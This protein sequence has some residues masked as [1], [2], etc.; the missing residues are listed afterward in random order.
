[1]KLKL[2]TLTLIPFLAFP[3]MAQ[4]SKGTL[5]ETLQSMCTE[6]QSAK[7]YTGDK[8]QVI[9]QSIYNEVAED[10]GIDS[11]AMVNYDCKNQKFET[12]LE[13]VSRENYDYNGRIETRHTS[14]NYNLEFN[15]RSKLMKI[16]FGKK[17]F[18]VNY[19]GKM[20]QFVLSLEIQGKLSVEKNGLISSKE[21]NRDI[22]SIVYSIVLNG[23]NDDKVKLSMKA[24]NGLL[25]ENEGLV[26]SGEADQSMIQTDSFVKATNYNESELLIEK[27][28]A[29]T[30]S[31]IV[32]D[33]QRA[34][35]DALVNQSNEVLLAGRLNLKEV[36]LAASAQKDTEAPAIQEVVKCDDAGCTPIEVQ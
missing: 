26:F 29:L 25:A 18:Y 23:S 1:M 12:L 9:S 34:Q 35:H 10:L 7:S 36:I 11:Y 20:H 21:M 15:E 16:N 6:S 13:V 5:K 4:E 8:I 27:A 33:G 28:Q 31:G 30:Q 24:P 17:P 14:Q 3:A 2:S 22:G 19:K 32:K